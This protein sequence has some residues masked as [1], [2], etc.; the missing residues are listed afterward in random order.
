MHPRTILLPIL[1]AG[2]ACATAQGAEP[3]SREAQVFKAMLEQP[4]MPPLYAPLQESLPEEPDENGPLDALIRH[5]SKIPQNQPGPSPWVQERF[6]QACERD[7]EKIH[8]LLWQIPPTPASA[9]RIRA[10]HDSLVSGPDVVN[11]RVYA[12]RDWLK[13]QTDTFR[14]ELLQDIR[15]LFHGPTDT[16]DWEAW[17]ALESL[18][19][20][21]WTTARPLVLRAEA[22]PNPIIQAFG[23][24]LRYQQAMTLGS[25]SPEALRP[26]IMALAEDATQPV[27]TRCRAADILCEYPWPGWEAWYLKQFKDPSLLELR[28]DG[29]SVLVLLSPLF[30]APKRWIPELVRL[31]EGSNPAARDNAINI[32]VE[33]PTS[34][35]SAEELRPL[36]PWLL[37][38]EW[39]RSP[40]RDQAL[41]AMARVCIPEA[42]PGMT[43][44]LASN[45]ASSQAWMAAEFLIRNPNPGAI[46]FL[47]AALE[48]HLNTSEC[49][50]HQSAFS[51]ALLA[52]GGLSEEKT[53]E[54]ITALAVQLERN[55]N[56]HDS[57]EQR[58]ISREVL[59]GWHFIMNQEV[60]IQLASALFKHA[61]R[62]E[63]GSPE[64]AEALRKLLWKH[65]V[66]EGDTEIIRRLGDSDLRLSDA[67][68]A[69]SHRDLV[70][71][72]HREALER[73]SQD[74]GWRGGMAAA[75]LDDSA[76]M[77]HLLTQGSPDARLALVATARLARVKLPLGSVAVQA[78]QG[79]TLARAADLYLKAASGF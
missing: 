22:H 31:I 8:R 36:L 38:P 34:W 78:L 74:K 5:W 24:C 59:L 40:R 55:P 12:L 7:P 9:R 64:V 51:L 28:Q 73:F 62:L 43:S 20:V 50:W 52:C 15:P 49:A 76:R 33:L 6:L 41:R 42:I 61:R 11:S 45:P 29:E 79:R 21:D 2:L 35:L 53:L 16:L 65:R 3:S 19:K 57:I 68:A 67:L 4:V 44:I 71:Q 30:L 46:P 63:R 1:L 58:G 13:Y 10:L 17:G 14:D 39:S 70:K 60:Q 23:L 18:S 75:L 25:E 26:R 37:D 69:V 48:H 66:P 77:N 72:N 54:M 32:L 27:W 47:Q 56:L